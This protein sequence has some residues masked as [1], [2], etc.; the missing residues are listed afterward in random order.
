MLLD[1]FLISNLNLLGAQIMNKAGLNSAP[2]NYSQMLCFFETLKSEAEENN[3]VAANMIYQVLYNF[4]SSVE[5]RDRHTSPRVFEDIFAAVFNT[6][7]TDVTHR[8]NPTPFK[9]ILKYDVLTK[10]EDWSIATDLSGNKREKVDVFI[11]SYPLSLKTLKGKHID[12]YGR[13]IDPSFNDEINVGSFS[14]RALFKGILSDK[15]LELLRDRKGGLGSRTQMRKNVLDPIKNSGKSAEF[16]ERLKLFFGFVYE[17]DVLIVIKSDYRIYLYFIPNKTFVNVICLLYEKNESKFEDVW[18][19]WENNNLRFKLTKFLYY[20]DHYKLPY[21]E[22]VLS[23]ASFE[24][25]QN[26]KS[27]NEKMNNT[28][29]SELNNLTKKD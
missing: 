7:S 6:E 18:H 28:I 25:N 22:I 20:I 2:K 9:E 10:K 24:K 29:K 17:E 23:L 14:Y 26:L 11:G 19:R 16:L 13:V 5:V 1:K 3:N 8:E 21:K 15:Q 27:F 4:V 12:E